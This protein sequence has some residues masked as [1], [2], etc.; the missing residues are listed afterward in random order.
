MGTKARELDFYF[1][2]RP[3]FVGL[4]AEDEE[5]RGARKFSRGQASGRRD[6][7][8]FQ[9]KSP[10]KRGPRTSDAIRFT[11]L[12]HHRD[13][14]H[15]AKRSRIKRSSSNIGKSK[16]REPATVHLTAR[17]GPNK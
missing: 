12:D 17:L 10:L 14:G 1:H 3:P 2:S 16:G 15:N 7:S 6:V 8:I 4:P 13:A 5:R 11:D 9:A